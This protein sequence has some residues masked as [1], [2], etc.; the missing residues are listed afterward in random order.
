VAPPDPPSLA[1]ATPPTPDGKKEGVAGS[2][3]GWIGEMDSLSRPITLASSCGNFP[4]D[5]K[6]NIKIFPDYNTAESN[7]YLD[8]NREF[9]RVTFG[10]NEDL[11]CDQLVAKSRANIPMRD[12]TIADVLEDVAI[13]IR[14]LADKNTHMC[15]LYD[16]RS[17]LLPGFS[18]SFARAKQLIAWTE[19]QGTTIDERLFAV[20]III[21]SGFSARLLKKVVEFIIWVT[22]PPMNPKVFED[23]EEEAM[24]F[25]RMKIK[26]YRAG[27]LKLKPY[28][29]EKCRF[30]NPPSVETVKKVENK[31]KEEEKNKKKRR[32]SS[33]GASLGLSPKK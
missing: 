3:T 17:Y 28:D 10:F 6:N 21:P 16:I 32:K 24:G 9:L 4:N 14:N 8:T 1:P 2:S 31:W 18:A 7:N 27:E 25:L 12:N 30:S 33:I 5:L 15:A 26:M 19:V 13:V 29:L 23:N 11:N 22:A 20:A